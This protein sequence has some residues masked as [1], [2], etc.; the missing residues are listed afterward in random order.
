MLRPR[1]YRPYAADGT[2]LEPVQ[3][4][5]LGYRLAR[6]FWGQ[7]YASEMSRALVSHGFRQ[8]RLPQIVG[9]VDPEHQA[10]VRV[11]EKAGL[12]HAGRARYEA[13]DVQLYRV[14]APQ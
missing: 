8:L 10:S 11:L 9:F 2:L 12:S 3:D 5:E 4:A 6:R 7:G 13:E 14:L 1:K